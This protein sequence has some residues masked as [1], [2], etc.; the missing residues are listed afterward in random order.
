MKK[1]ACIKPY[2]LAW[3]LKMSFPRTEKETYKSNKPIM[4]SMLTMI[5]ENLRTQTHP[6]IFVLTFLRVL[7]YTPSSLNGQMESRTKCDFSKKTNKEENFWKGKR[8]E[9]SFRRKGDFL[10]GEKREAPRNVDLQRGTFSLLFCANDHTA[11]VSSLETR[12]V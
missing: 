8:R 12:K 3:R 10:E 7:I 6:P 9:T 4:K 1:K 5:S 11:P 2:T